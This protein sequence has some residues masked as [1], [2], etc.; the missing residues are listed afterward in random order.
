[1]FSPYDAVLLARKGPLSK[2]S[3]TTDVIEYVDP[4]SRGYINTLSL[5]LKEQKSKTPQTIN[6]L[7]DYIDSRGI[8]YSTY[9]FSLF[10][11]Q[12]ILQY[13]LPTQY[14]SRIRA[15]N[16]IFSLTYY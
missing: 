13:A 14:T 4:V 11:Y 10:S 1:M 15:C 9:Y 5:T 6:P 8:K 2:E 12:V 16:G 3:L 7:F